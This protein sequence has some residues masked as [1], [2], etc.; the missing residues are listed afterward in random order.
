MIHKNSSAKFLRFLWL[1]A[2]KCQVCSE[3]NNFLKFIWLTFENDHS[4]S[5]KLMLYYSKLLCQS[6]WNLPLKVFL[7]FDPV[8]FTWIF[9]YYYARVRLVLYLTI[10]TLDWQLD[11]KENVFLFVSFKY[12]WPISW[13]LFS[14][15]SWSESH[16]IWWSWDQAFVII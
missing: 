11:G 9:F 14:L 5:Q 3:L 2:L 8:S 7:N 1:L 16:L 4:K 15:P 6:I 10:V 13:S 12:T